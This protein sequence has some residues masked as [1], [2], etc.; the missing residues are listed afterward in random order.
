MVTGGEGTLTVL[1]QDD[2]PIQNHNH[3]LKEGSF[4]ALT[5]ST[6]VVLSAGKEDLHTVR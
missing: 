5:P 4:F 3:E 6:T 2:K 1:D